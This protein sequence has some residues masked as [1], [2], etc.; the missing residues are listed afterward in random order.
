MEIIS[1]F[2]Q[3]PLTVEATLNWTALA[4]VGWVVIRALGLL[5]VGRLTLRFRLRTLLSATPLPALLIPGAALAKS[6]PVSE[7][8]SSHSDR[9]QIPP[10]LTERVPPL[11]SLVGA[12]GPQGVHPA[13]HR[14]ARPG[15]SPLFPRA[16]AWRTV[17]DLEPWERGALDLRRATKTRSQDPP[18]DRQTDYYTVLPGDT[19]WDIAAKVLKTDDQR[20]IARFWPTLHR[21]NVDVVGRN[22]NLIRPGQ[23]L[24]IPRQGDL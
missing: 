20:A 7:G 16:A 9:S 12:G 10:A 17:E 14:S 21:A 4:C 23:V 8:H 1:T 6:T 22:P 5:P 3:T 18:D 13:I 19:L 15:T 11:R 24:Y 2:I